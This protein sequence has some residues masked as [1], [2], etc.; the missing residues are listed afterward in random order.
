MSAI[1]AIRL[2]SQ[3]SGLNSLKHI[4]QQHKLQQHQ[5]QPPHLP[6]VHQK[7][8]LRRFQ[9]LHKQKFRH[10]LHLNL[11]RLNLQHLRVRLHN[12]LLKLRQLPH[13]QLL[14]LRQL[15]LNQQHNK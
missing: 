5:Q 13:N 9:N 8:E 2:L 6:L 15:L 4:H 12:Q 3:P 11:L 14:K 1:R 7:V 10:Q